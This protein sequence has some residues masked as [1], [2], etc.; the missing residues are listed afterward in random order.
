MCQKVAS[1]RF[2]QRLGYYS[3]LSTGFTVDYFDARKFEKKIKEAM[4]YSL[5]GGK[6]LR[7]SLLLGVYSV[8][9]DDSLDKALPFAAALEMIHT[10]SLIHDDLPA[11]DDDDLRRGK[12]SSHRMFGEA[13]AILAGDALLNTAAECM[14]SGIEDFEA[15]GT[16]AAL[17]IMKAAGAEGMIGGQVL[18]MAGLSSLEELRRMYSMK[19]GALIKAAAV[20]G[21][22]LGG[23][24]DSSIRSMEAFAEKAG[25]AFQ[26][27]DDLLDVFGNKDI[28][29]KPTGSDMKNGK[30]TIA[31]LLGVDEAT[32][33]M[34]ETAAGALEELGKISED[35]WFLEELMDFII[36]REG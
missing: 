22:I 10:Y 13:M 35:T 16:M 24:S 25:F 19:T 36:N 34:Y 18:D 32:R 14:L 5:S 28:I 17:E 20:A 23:G 7:P 21:S 11:M 8:F 9:S 3:N 33:L 2:I 31:S 1:E 27:K 29:G 30:I 4:H 26:I 6:H 15:R 12:P